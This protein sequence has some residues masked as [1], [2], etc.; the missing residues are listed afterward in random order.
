MTITLEMRP[1]DAPR[2][3]DVFVAETGPFSIAIDGYVIGGPRFDP[4]GPRANFNHHEFVDRLATR[5]TCAQVLMALR[6]GLL[7][8]FRDKDGPRIV[9]YTNDCDEDV[10]TTWFLLK[11]HQIS[12]NTMN[13]VL[14]RLVHMEDMLDAT[15]GAYP[16]P[17]DLPTLEALAWI[18]EPYRRARLNGDL[19]RRDPVTFTGIV[20]DVENRIKN[21][22]MGQGE[23]LHLDARYERV[24]GNAQW[25]MI[26]E[27][28]A[29]A[30]TGA[31]ADGIYAYVS[32]RGRAGGR[33]DYTIGR[34]S[35]FINFPVAK[36]WDALNEADD[37]Q[38]KPDRWGGGEQVGGSPRVG[39]SGLTPSQV[40][41]I[42]N[43]VSSESQVA[44]LAR[45]Q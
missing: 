21:H 11:N 14:N 43:R 26:R 41:E 40:E 7:R 9:V 17:A 32:V 45:A 38:D 28:G 25:A 2:E 23:K 19:Q 27:V 4:V 20:T 34:M 13:P 3:W 8:K 35:P 24:G 29:Q 18:F 15:A 6:Q 42:V 16:F 37:C 10:C 36:F 12:E 31:F 30:K 22:I 39:G 5:A 1:Q 44:E 33:F